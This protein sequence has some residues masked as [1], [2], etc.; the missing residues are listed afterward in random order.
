MH[1]T[2]VPALRERMLPETERRVVPHAHWVNF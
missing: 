2:A 1:W